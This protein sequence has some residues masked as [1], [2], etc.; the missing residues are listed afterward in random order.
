MCLCR[1]HP[2]RIHARI[3]VLIHVFVQYVLIF[4][5]MYWHTLQ[6]CSRL[7]LRHHAAGLLSAMSASPPAI[8]PLHHRHRAVGQDSGHAWPRHGCICIVL[9]ARRSCAHSGAARPP[10]RGSGQRAAGSG[11]RAAGSARRARV[12][13]TQQGA[14]D[15]PQAPPWR[16][17]MRALSP[18]WRQASSNTGTNLAHPLPA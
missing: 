6:P 1:T 12:L 5:H 3:H 16:P 13:V 14:C 15:K 17:A 10:Q 18:R 11:Q 2:R 8:V 7:H 4:G 9:V